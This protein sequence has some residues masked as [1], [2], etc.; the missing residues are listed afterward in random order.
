LK[1]TMCHPIETPLKVL[2]AVCIFQIKRGIDGS[3]DRHFANKENM[4]LSLPSNS[5][6]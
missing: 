5:E 4:L 1:H 2:E 6:Q 3:I